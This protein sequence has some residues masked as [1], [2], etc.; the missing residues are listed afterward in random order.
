[1]LAEAIIRLGRPIVYSQLPNQER[2]RWLT[3]VDN[4]SCKNFFQNVFVCELDGSNSAYQF[5]NV[6][7]GEGKELQADPMRNVAYPILFPQGGNPLRAQG[8][9]PVPCYLMYD[10]HIKGMKHP[11]SFSEEVILPRLR[12]TVSYRGVEEERLEEV[13]TRVAAILASHY[14]DLISE[15]KQLGILYILDHSLPVF[16]KFPRI[17]RQDPRYLRIAESKLNDGEHVYLDGNEA[18]AGI[19]EAKFSEAKTL[20]HAKN[21]VSTFSNRKEDEVSSIYNKFWLWLSPTWEM[22][23]SI[24]WGKKDWTKGIKI[25]R[26]HYEAFL[27]GTQLL[28]RITLP[29]SSGM[30]KEMF[31]PNT[32]VE[33]K[34][35]MK[36][37]SFE[38][39][40]GAP[41]VLPLLDGDSQQLYEKYRQMLKKEEKQSD[42]DLHLEL[43]AGINRVVPRVSDEHR[44]TLLYYSGDLSRGN[45]HVRMVIEDVIPTVAE[46]LQKIIRSI[47]QKELMKI[48]KAFGSD[49]DKPF[50]RIRSL[51]VMLS[52]AYGP[53]YVWSSLQTVFHKQVLTIDRLFQAASRRLVEL[54]NKEDHWGMVDE[55]IFLYAFLAFCNRYHQE[56]VKTDRR[57]R[58]MADWIA[59]LERYHEGD[60]SVKDVE[61]VDV[62]GFVSGLL[63]KQFSQS[64]HHK[65]GKDFVK[66]RVM[67]FGSRLTP[68]MIWRNGLMRC[69]E[70]KEQWDM[71]LGGNYFQVLPH[72]LLGFLEADKNDSLVSERDAFMTAFWSG[73]LMYQ[74]TK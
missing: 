20:G 70:L 46:A 12:N 22:P 66:H 71:H 2:L 30:L 36:P 14:E 58:T 74:K 52:N 67:K 65:T 63:L 39:I 42:S 13:A 29:I 19:I 50:Y 48:R 26:E 38:P 57:V 61:K 47:N 60:I 73:Y 16:G 25:D 53:G 31:A 40:Y 17:R 5:M 54:M 34:R 35:H 18:L 55:L 32:N 11:S 72:V 51:P 44:L 28:K 27:Y 62:L 41:I 59:M 8:I 15:E 69:E 33:A 56:V 10:P 43:L 1:M 4:E 21:A 6:T 3:D 45:M 64:Y 7:T 49:S 24:Y 68:H 9:Y 37:T 23:R